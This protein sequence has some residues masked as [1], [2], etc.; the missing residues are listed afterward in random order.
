MQEVEAWEKRM[1]MIV[2]MWNQ[3]LGMLGSRL[4]SAIAAIVGG[5]TGV[6]FPQFTV[7]AMSLALVVVGV[8]WAVRWYRE[9]K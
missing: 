2:R 3:V 8:S 7:R 6:F 1:D 5:S 9:R 4:L